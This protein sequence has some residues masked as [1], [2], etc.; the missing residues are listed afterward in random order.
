[1]KIHYDEYPMFCKVFG[2]SIGILLAI[3]ALAWALDDGMAREVRHRSIASRSMC[4]FYG[5]DI[6]AYARANWKAEPCHE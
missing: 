3:L 2:F 6:N 5:N 1:M 4:K